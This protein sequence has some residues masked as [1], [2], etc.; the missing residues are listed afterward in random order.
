MIDRY[1]L[2]NL[3]PL[4]LAAVLTVGFLIYLIW[5]PKPPNRKDRDGRS[6]S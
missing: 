2:V 4:L 6:D 5:L 1:N 3:M